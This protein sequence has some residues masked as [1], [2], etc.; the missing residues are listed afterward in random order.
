MRF[1]GCDFGHSDKRVRLEGMKNVRISLFGMIFVVI[2]SVGMMPA[3]ARAQSRIGAVGFPELYSFDYQ[4][5]NYS[6]PLTGT[7]LRRKWGFKVYKVAH[8]MEVLPDGSD[9]FQKVLEDGPAKQLTLQYLRDVPGSKIQSV[10]RE[11]FLL[12]ADADELKVIREPMVRLLKA[13]EQPVKKGDEF[14][15]RWFQGGRVVF[16]SNGTESGSV[17]NVIFA[18]VLWSIWCGEKAVVNRIQLLARAGS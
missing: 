9:V 1:R 15:L 8:Y 12:N 11:G 6:L 17:D 10:L 16:Y 3:F 4:S 18:R 13:C 14:I 7:G 2:F 5:K